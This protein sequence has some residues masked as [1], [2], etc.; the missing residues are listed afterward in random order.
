[1]KRVLFFGTMMAAFT[2][3][4]SSCEKESQNP[5]EEITYL[6]KEEGE[7]DD[8]SDWYLGDILDENGNPLPEVEL[9][10]VLN[11][12]VVAH[13]KTDI[14]GKFQFNNLKRTQYILKASKTGYQNY[15]SVISVNSSTNTPH[16]IQMVLE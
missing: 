12:V 13:E 11:N 7:D 15:T 6:A 8:A 5:T 14:Y 9:S 4:L 3:G 10:L 1:M 16:R 2:I